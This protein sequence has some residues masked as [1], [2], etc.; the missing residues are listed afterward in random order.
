MVTTFSDLV[1]EAREG[2]RAD[3]RKAGLTHTF[4]STLGRKFSVSFV[5]T[6][7]FR[8]GTLEGWGAIE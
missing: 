7:S 3:G 4:G 1:G 8:P 6:V 5:S 2:V